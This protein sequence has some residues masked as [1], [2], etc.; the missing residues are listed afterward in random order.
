MGAVRT[1]GHSIIVAQTRYSY[2]YMHPLRNTGSY[3]MYH[4]T[5]EV[6]ALEP[7]KTTLFYTM[8]WDD[9][10]L[11]GDTA[12]QRQADNYR[13]L[14]NKMLRNLKKRSERGTLTPQDK[15]SPVVR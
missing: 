13:A 1:I 15:Q 6:R 3:P 9:S 14:F 10:T 12:R 7:D 5:L 11:P 2:T 4:G 8:V